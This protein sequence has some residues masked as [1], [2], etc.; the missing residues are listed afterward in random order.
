[1]E[2]YKISIESSRTGCKIIVLGNILPLLR[3]GLNSYEGRNQL[4]FLFDKAQEDRPKIAIKG[5]VHAEMTFYIFGR[6]SS[7]D[8]SDYCTGRPHIG[9]LISAAGE[10]LGDILK[11]SE[12]AIASINAQ[13]WYSKTPR[14]EFCIRAIKQ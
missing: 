1:M 13:K 14:S 5:P 9:R 8:D 11:D 6:Q 10:L 4:K 7:S 12:L 2:E 3:F